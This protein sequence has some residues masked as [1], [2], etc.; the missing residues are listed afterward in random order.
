[1]AKTLFISYSHDS[2]EHMDWVKQFASDL[3]ALGEFEIY[4]DQNLPKGLSFTRFM[5]VGIAN[6]D[7]VLVIG[8]PEYK[9]RLKLEKESL[10]KKRL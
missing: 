9:K 4:L 10:S 6:A 8:T 3:E 7:K 1:M 2:K 5:E